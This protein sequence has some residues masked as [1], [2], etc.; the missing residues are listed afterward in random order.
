MEFDYKLPSEKGGRRG[1]QPQ[2]PCRKARALKSGQ[3][4]TAG[5]VHGMEVWPREGSA[6]CL[7]SRN[8]QNSQKWVGD[9]AGRPSRPCPFSG[10]GWLVPRHHR[11]ADPACSSVCTFSGDPPPH[12]TWTWATQY[13]LSLLLLWVCVV[14]E[15][16]PVTFRGLLWPK[17]FSY[18]LFLSF[19]VLSV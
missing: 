10:G 13:N 15:L 6:G 19:P 18:N 1:Q 14:A 12:L 16:G 17:W 7:C 11:R 3:E 8:H 5:R 9:E 4:A 2:Q